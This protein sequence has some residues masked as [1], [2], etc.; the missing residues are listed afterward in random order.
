[1]D[2][3]FIA[4]GSTPSAVAARRPKATPARWR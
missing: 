4:S 3:T 1:M 2:A